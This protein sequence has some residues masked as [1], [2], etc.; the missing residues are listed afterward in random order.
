MNTQSSGDQEHKISKKEYSRICDDARVQYP[1]DHKLQAGYITGAT[2]EYLRRQ[3]APISDEVVEEVTKEDIV[4]SHFA[5]EMPELLDSYGESFIAKVEWC[6]DEWHKKLS[7]ALG[8][9]DL[10]GVEGANGDPNRKF[11]KLEVVS[12][13]VAIAAHVRKNG[14]GPHS[15][16]GSLVIDLLSRW[17]TKFPILS[18]PK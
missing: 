12:I 16:V 2:V 11:S 8:G 4:R 13:G 7:P 3:S 18:N 9:V 15:I 17:E 6:M 1:E 5:D 14:Y 10:T